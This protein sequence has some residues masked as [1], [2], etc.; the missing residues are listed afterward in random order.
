MYKRPL[1]EKVCQGTQVSVNSYIDCATT[2][3][4]AYSAVVTPSDP[5]PRLTGNI[6]ELRPRC[7]IDHGRNPIWLTDPYDDNTPPFVTI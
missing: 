3:H 5:A 7:S 1:L 6:Y 4:T 2:D